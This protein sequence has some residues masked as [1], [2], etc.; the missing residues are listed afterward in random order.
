[1]GGDL[2]HLLLVIVLVV[3]AVRLLLVTCR[4][5]DWKETTMP[6]CKPLLLALSIV[7]AA[8]RAEAQP[9]V[10]THET[11]EARIARAEHVVVGTTAKVTAAHFTSSR[12]A[13][14]SLTV[15]APRRAA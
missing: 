5:P 10:V 6:A 4:G 15:S 12:P 11:L 2:I 8:G 3:V 13:R 9:L 1:M 7:L 14:F